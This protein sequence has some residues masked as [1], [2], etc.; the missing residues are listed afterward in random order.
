M[1]MMVR[2]YNQAVL[3]AARQFKPDFVLVFKGEYLEGH[4][5]RQLI[6]E[7]YPVVNYFPDRSFTIEGKILREAVSSYSLIITTKP[8]HLEDLS[9][10]V[11]SERIHLVPH[12][13]DPEIHRPAALTPWEKTYYGSD[14]SF[15]GTFTPRKGSLLRDLVREKPALGLRIWGNGW[16]PRL[17]PDLARVIVG[18]PAEGEEYAKVLSAS[19]INLAIQ[20]D[21]VPGFNRVCQ[22][23]VSTRTFEIPACG[24]F[25][26]HER[27]G[28]VESFFVEGKEMACFSGMRELAEKIEHFLSHEEERRRIAAEGH[29]RCTTSDYRYDDR[30][31]KLLDIMAAGQENP[32]KGSGKGRL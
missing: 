31:K 10:V 8:Y 15:V 18:Q 14:V 28:E 29:L 12:G 20:S 3:R 22:D 21:P 32:T 7:G 25:M 5:I 17:H 11:P 4:T 26:L 19:R 1:P 23:E 27:T 6:A 24:G 13:Y 2:D 30:M 16:D 9:G